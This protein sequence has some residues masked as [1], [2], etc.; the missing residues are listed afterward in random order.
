VKISQGFEKG[1]F[2]REANAEAT[3]PAILFVHGLG[4]SGLCFEHLLHA[5]DLAKHRLLMPDLPGYGRSPWCEEAALGLV[6]QAD[7][8]ME[9]VRTKTGD[10]VIVL[11]HSMGGVVALLMA[12]RHPEQVRFV[13]DVD[14]NKSPGDCVFSS[15]ACEYDLDTFSAAGFDR[16]R[17]AIHDKG[18]EDLAQ[19]GYYVSLRLADPRAY[20][21]NSGELVEMSTPRDMARRLAELP[22]GKVYIAGVPGGASQ[23]THQLLREAGV[24]TVCI[25]PSGHWPFIDQP[26]AFLDTLQEIL[27]ST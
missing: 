17:A 18:Y 23:L 7:H 4:E 5:P 6:E 26:A 2:Y 20:H 19:R 13:V 11:G 16:M 27:K 25:E 24:R 14:G 12:E 3:G 10:P 1:M 21:H 22:M 9:W 15:Q 8:L